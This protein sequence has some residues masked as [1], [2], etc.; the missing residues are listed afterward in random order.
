MAWVD[1]MIVIAPLVIV[2]FI[3]L[4]TRRYVKGVAD[5]LAA[6]RVAGRYVVAVASGEAGLGLITAVAMFEIYYKAG[7]GIRFW[8]E[9]KTPIMMILM[10][11]GFAIYRYRETRSMTMGQ[12][13]EIR[14]SKSFRIFAATLQSISG[15][16]NYGLFPAVGARFLVYFCD[17]PP[18]FELFGMNWP[19]FGLLMAGFL[20]LAVLIVMLGGQIAV[21]TTDCVLGILSY[22]MYLIVVV[23]IVVMFPWYDQ[24]APA[25]M[26][27]AP[28]E[29]MLNPFDIGELRGF[30]LFYAM[31]GIFAFVYTRLAWSGE[32]GYNAAAVS[33]HEQKM[34]AILGTWRAGFSLLM[35]TLV[36]VAA[37]TYMNHTDHA[38][39]ASVTEAQLS[40]KTLNDIQPQPDYNDGVVVTQAMVDTR[41][42][43]LS[44]KENQVYKTIHGQMLVPVALRDLLPVGVTGV[45]CALMVFMLISTDTTYLHSWSSILIQDLVLPFRKRPFKPRHQLLLLR[46]AIVGVALFAFV[47]SLYFGQ[48]TYILMFFALTGSIWLGG[49]G[50]VILGGLYWKKGTTLGAW[51]ALGTGSSLA[52]LGFIGQQ[53]WVDWI[54]P[55]IAGNPALLESVTWIIEGISYPFEPI[56]KWRI[57]PEG[58]PLN[59]QEVYFLTMIMAIT[60]YVGVSLLTCRE[61]FNIDRMLHRG[62]Y[63]REEDSI[64]RDPMSTRFP[65]TIS[66]LIRTLVGID[67]QFTRGDKILSW[68]VFIYSMGWGFGTFLVVVIWNL[69]DPWPLTWW[70]NW[71]LVYNIIVAAIIGVV[72]SVWFFIGGIWDLNRMFKRLA[73]KDRNILDDGRVIGHVN[74][75]DLE[76]I[77]KSSI[78]QLA[79]DEREL[80]SANPENMGQDDDKETKS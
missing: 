31:V 25:L 45:F 70:A 23:A 67:G 27:R 18:N 71:F 58:F 78:D 11:T 75:E 7:F 19:T 15:I 35:I 17:M 46:L 56:I 42:A 40:W 29:S 65:R 33:P 74:A 57:T 60:A 80:K 41:V 64:G 54:Y 24:M 53:S 38:E 34:G 39:Q 37:F 21:M 48:V 9:L 8:E 36:A 16:I 10:L 59:G 52:L 44:A 49:A 1:W 30:N 62:K 61:N 77:E 28:G 47:F 69:I 5:Y 32:S 63:R 2:I 72:S 76:S 22:P 55:A 51:A 14:Y 26:D 50:A 13:F 4:R 43:E 12:F 6:G 3:G 20:A 68:S 66:G 73:L 79:P